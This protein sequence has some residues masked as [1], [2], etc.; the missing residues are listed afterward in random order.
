MPHV[1]WQFLPDGRRYR[2]PP[3][4]VVPGMSNQ[5]YNDQGQLDVL[6]QRHFLQTGFADLLL[7]ELWRHLKR[8]GLWDD[9]LIVVAADHGVAFIKGRRDRR[10]LD[11]ENYGEIAPIPLFIKAPG[12]KKGR[13][14]DAYVETID[15][16]PTIF[17]ILN[18][19]PKVKMDGHS[20]FSPVVQA[21]RNAAGS[22]SATRSS[23]CAS[24]PAEFERR[25]ALVR[26]RNHRLF[27]TG[28]DGPDR[29]LPDR[30]APGA[31]RPRACPRAGAG[32]RWRSSRRGRLRERGPA[33]RLRA[34][35][36][37]WAGSTAATPG[38]DIAVAVNGRIAAVGNTF[39][40]AEGEDGRVLLGD[41][42]GVGAARAGATGSTCSR[43]SAERLAHP[44]LG[45]I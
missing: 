11:A 43:S 36:P 15:I 4:D 39:A 5:S 24:P 22:S 12:Q 26:E 18:I 6:L 42:A 38:R 40:L 41:G 8:E 32:A 29:H 31:A 25:E 10:R 17:D 14:N 13:V 7:Q 27:G 9:S 3:N 20:A 2:K 34:H 45:G 44:R 30:P 35:P 28:S 21:P 23:R 37:R 33:L 19:D 16:L 1:P